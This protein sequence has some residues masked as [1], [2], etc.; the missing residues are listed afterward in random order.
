MI[1]IFNIEVN[2]ALGNTRYCAQLADAKLEKAKIL[3]LRFL[4]GYLLIDD[5]ER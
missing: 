5:I 3:D 2:K 4:R 1:N